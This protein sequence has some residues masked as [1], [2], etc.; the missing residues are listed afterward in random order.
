MGRRPAARDHERY[1]MSTTATILVIDD[2]PT[3]LKLACYVL[4]GEGYALLQARDAQ[5]ALEVLKH[6]S[7][8]LRRHT[9]AVV[10]DLDE[11]VMACLRFGI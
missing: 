3:N 6:S 7:P 2:N 1:S 10:L 8:D 9:C 4:E 5:K 11:D